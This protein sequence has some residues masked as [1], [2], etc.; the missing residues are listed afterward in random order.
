MVTIGFHSVGSVGLDR[1]SPPNKFLFMLVTKI[2]FFS[3][4]CY[5][6]NALARNVGRT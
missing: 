6:F 2:T 4:T 5:R 3:F 1:P